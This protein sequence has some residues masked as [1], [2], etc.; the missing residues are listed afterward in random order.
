ML[1][2]ILRASQQEDNHHEQVKTR[3]TVV[4]PASTDLDEDQHGARQ[5]DLTE[6]P[7]AT[8]IDQAGRNCILPSP[9]P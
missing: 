7:L 8:E 5:P 6:N 9:I 1:T 3:I 2:S 4:P